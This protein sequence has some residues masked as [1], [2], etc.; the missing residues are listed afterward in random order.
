MFSIFLNYSFFLSLEM[1]TIIQ[2]I[3]IF[4]FEG[5]FYDWTFYIVEKFA[6]S[7][8][9]TNA[10]KEKTDKMTNIKAKKLM[11]LHSLELRS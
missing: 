7:W 3:A 2:K 5:I 6:S 9:P 8:R 11:G 10:F 1:N 4:V